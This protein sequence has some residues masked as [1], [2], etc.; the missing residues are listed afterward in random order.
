MS[1]PRCPLLPLLLL[2]TL[3]APAPA[4]ELRLRD[5]EVIHGHIEERAKG[6]LHVRIGRKL[7]K[8][9]AKDV[10]QILE[11]GDPHTALLVARE[12]LAP[13]DAPGRA[14]LA[15]QA[16]RYRMD[17]LA[18]SLA[19][20]SV[21]LDPTLAGA[22]GLLGRVQRGADWKP[23][24][25]PGWGAPGRTGPRWG[26]AR[27]AA[28]SRSGGS[29]STEAA[30]ERGL[31]WLASHQDDDGRLDAD[32]F[33]RH[34]PAED[35]CAGQGGGHHGE[36]VPCGYDGVTTAVALMAWLASGSTPVSGPFRKQ[37][38]KA[39]SF[40]VGVL[41]GG[42]AGAYGLWNH[43]FCTQAVADAYAVTRDP[44][45]R[46]VLAAAVAGLLRFQRADGGWSYYMPI[47]DLPTTGVAGSALG[48][49]NQAGIPVPTLAVDRLWEF[50]DARVAADSG[51]SEYHKGAE[52]KGYTPTRANTAA[53]LTVRALFAAQSQAP[54]LARQAAALGGRKP[55]W[56]LEFKEVKTRDGR[57]VRAQIGNLYPYLWYYTTM[58]LWERGGSSWSKWFGGLKKA[59]LSGQRKEGSARGSWDP[60]GT[61]SSSA[62]R[63]FITGLC[64]LMLQTPYRYPR[65]R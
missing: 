55:V 46:N 7:R 20:E 65:S 43:G 53:A 37:V 10:E 50:L 2:L 15:E 58:A 29:R 30:V 13:E 27:R 9:A 23:G 57:K 33:Q 6:K 31:A 56:K 63:V 52:R 36:R 48:L 14:A 39:L 42:P 62:G 34:D 45:L 32:G 26:Q 47:G 18:R 40:C 60:L 24:R 59:L 41:E 16:W 21:A 11:G 5:G 64:I 19:L 4:E 3:A 61:Y 44:E 22:Q 1:V 49:A 51:R 28:L 25:P 54:H 8:L 17:D 35:P 12:A 38:A